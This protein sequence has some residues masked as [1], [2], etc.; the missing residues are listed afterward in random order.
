MKLLEQDAVVILY[1]ILHCR[2]LGDSVSL[3]DTRLTAVA[4]SDVVPGSRQHDVEIHPVDANAGVVL[5]PEIDVLRDTEAE[6][7]SC[8]E[9]ALPQ[10]KIFDCQTLFQDLNRLSAAHRAVH[11]D[12]FVTPDAERTDGEAGFGEDRCL[13]SEGLEDVAGTHEAVSALPHTD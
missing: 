10:L 9:V 7:A 4:V 8:G 2:R 5:D 1:K 6:V 13:P 3:T 12:L 11:R